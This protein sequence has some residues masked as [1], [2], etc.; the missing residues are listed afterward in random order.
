MQEY[1]IVCKGTVNLDRDK[2]I[3]Q[4][5]TPAREFCKKF[6]IAS[7]KMSR[8]WKGHRYIFILSYKLVFYVVW[9]FID[10]I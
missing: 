1:Y 7:C 3:N 9:S 6:I 10:M 5:F 4:S 8:V 2:L